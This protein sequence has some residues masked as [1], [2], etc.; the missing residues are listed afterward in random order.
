MQQQVIARIRESIEG[1]R[2]PRYA[3]IP[4]VGL[5][6]EQTTKYLSDCLAPVID[7]EITGTMISN[8]V[9]RGVVDSPVRKQYSR[10]QIAYLI[11]AMC[12]KQALSLDNIKLM[13]SI[14]KETY[15]AEIAYDYFCQEFENMVE[16]VFG[17]KPLPDVVGVENTSEKIMLRNAIITA[18]HK[19]YLDKLF[20]ALQPK[21]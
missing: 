15:P 3:Y 13:M 16:Y 17:V 1:F 18:A 20:A 9:K 6:L 12:A 21:T 8:Y 10:D 5:Y 2:L 14:Q 7:C 11:F 4:D 19:I